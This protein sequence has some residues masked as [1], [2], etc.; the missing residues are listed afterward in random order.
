[1][2]DHL[3]NNHANTVPGLEVTVLT[4]I[5]QS[6]PIVAVQDAAISALGFLPRLN[7]LEARRGTFPITPLPHHS[8]APYPNGR[9]MPEWSFPADGRTLLTVGGTV[10]IWTEE[11]Q[12]RLFDEYFRPPPAL[13][14]ICGSEVEMVLSCLG[15]QV[16]LLVA[17]EGCGNKATVSRRLSDFRKAYLK[18]AS[19]NGSGQELVQGKAA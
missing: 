15:E 3:S 18:A 16:S 7:G 19:S 4:S 1:M 10:R 17:C 13:C 9:E 14:G 11:E 2:G 12:Q 5:G 6:L 8:T